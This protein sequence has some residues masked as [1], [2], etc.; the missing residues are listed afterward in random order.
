M[1]R[2]PQFTVFGRGVLYA[3][4]TFHFLLVRPGVF[5]S[6]PCEALGEEFI[7]LLAARRLRRTRRGSAE[8]CKL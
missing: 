5:L 2:T 8:E 4:V 7:E 3:V 6:H 1:F